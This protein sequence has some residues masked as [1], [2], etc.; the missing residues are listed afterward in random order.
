MLAYDIYYVDII[1]VV[2]KMS[3]FCPHNAQ[4]NQKNKPEK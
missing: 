1:T 2:Y 4:Q 3:L